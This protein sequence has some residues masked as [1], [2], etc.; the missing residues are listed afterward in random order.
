M[1]QMIR[2]SAMTSPNQFEINNACMGPLSHFGQ[3]GKRS[4]RQPYLLAAVRTAV[5]FLSRLFSNVEHGNLLREGRLMH[6]G[7]PAETLHRWLVGNFSLGVIRDL[8]R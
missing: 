2:Y 3:G 8:T 7:N 1:V 5:K 4:R 6:N